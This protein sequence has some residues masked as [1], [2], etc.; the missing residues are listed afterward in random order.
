MERIL[1]R[2]EQS[3]ALA[4]ADIHER[5]LAAV[6]VQQL[7]HFVEQIRL[8]GLIRRIE[9]ADEACFPGHICARR[10]HAVLPIVFDIPIALPTPFG[11]R[12][13]QELPAD[14]T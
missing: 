4:G 5:E 10:V 3:P 13:A 9:Q 2:H 6:D 8:D 11:H 14:R 7:N 1:R 12:I